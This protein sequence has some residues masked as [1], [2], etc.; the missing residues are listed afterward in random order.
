MRYVSSLPPSPVIPEEEE[1]TP[2]RAIRLVKPVEPRS[3]MPQVI[4]HFNRNQVRPG[5]EAASGPALVRL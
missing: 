4:Q 2:T 3:R 1:P 5:G